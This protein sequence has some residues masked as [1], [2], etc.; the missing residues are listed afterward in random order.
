MARRWKHLASEEDID[1]LEV[2]LR[3]LFGIEPRHYLLGAFLGLV[4]VGLFSLLVLPGLLHPGERWTVSS[5]P[6]GAAVYV[7]GE[8]VG[9]TP[10]SIF[11]PAG[12]RD[13]SLTH[14]H[15]SYEQP[16]EVQRRLL[17]SLIFPLRRE[18]RIPLQDSGAAE[19]A[20]ALEAGLADVAAWALT[21][22]AS[23][24]FQ[25]PPVAHE[26]ARRVWAADRDGR[27][28]T[29]AA[30]DALRRTLVLHATP[31]H[32]RDIS[33]ALMR[34]G[35]PGAVVGPTTVADLVRFF[36][37][38]DNESPIRARIAAELGAVLPEALRSVRGSAWLES[39]TDA[40]STALLAG[41]LTPDERAVPP[42]RSETLR[43]PGIELEM[44]RVPPGSHVLG[45]PLRDPA[46][47]G[48]PVRVEREFWLA[49]SELSRGAFRR[50]LDDDASWRPEQ[51]ER[52]VAEQLVD[53]EYLAD[54]PEDWRR[55]APDDATPLRH[56]SW[57]AA[58]AFVEWLN[59]NVPAGER[60][61]LLPGAVFT[62]PDPARWEYA[63][64]LNGLGDNAPRRSADALPVSALRSGALGAVGLAGNLW[65][66]TDAWYAPHRSIEPAAAG[67]QRVVM[68]GSFASDNAAPN[69]VGAQ[70]PE[71]STPYLGFRVM[72]RG[73]E[74]QVVYD[75]R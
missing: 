50:F 28:A 49:R 17:G 21:G 31:D 33:A 54:W 72:L 69:L 74:D 24:Q 22:E 53:D 56:V 43:G 71:W 38:L 5:A 48:I 64:F 4:G 35:S 57:S 55:V 36:V 20:R 73:A 16:I 63:A 19:R 52:L 25:Q 70:P 10:L 29:P 51:R 44:V 11:V 1:E 75:G 65:E 7:D 47:Q 62:L 27:Q 41:A 61:R 23:A 26:L 59:R 13:L 8:L 60:G 58:R 14:G 30:I 3:P 66:W 2:R 67:D 18:L 12:I 15:L 40:V 39:R 42:S 37:R 45:Y 46:L 9:A 6:E 34:L 32:L 68:G